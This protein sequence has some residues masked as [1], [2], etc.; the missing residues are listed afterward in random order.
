MCGSN[1]NT[2]WD[3]ARLLIEHENGLVNQ[4]LGWML[5][6]N[7]F[8]FTA[9]ALSLSASSTIATPPQGV[10]TD[11]DGLEHLAQTLEI[12]RMAV[13]LAGFLSTVVAAL[14][15]SAAG[16]AIRMICHRTNLSGN[17]LPLTGG[18]SSSFVGEMSALLFPAILGGVWFGWCFWIWS[19]GSSAGLTAGVVGFLAGA[20]IAVLSIF[21]VRSMSASVESNRST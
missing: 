4:R 17:E 1:T 15:V 7:G 8:L 6:F 14:G 5:A 9:L 16:A 3:N 2:P 18:G 21:G 10:S 13:G 12:L 19:E 11:T 20:A